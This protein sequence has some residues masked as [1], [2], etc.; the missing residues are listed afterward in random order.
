[1]HRLPPSLFRHSARARFL[2]TV[3]PRYAQTTFLMP[4]LSPTMEEGKIGTWRFKEG[5][6]FNEGDILLSVET[7]KAE[8]EV[9]AQEE[10][11]V[12]KVLV[13]DHAE[14]IKV[15]R[16]IAILVEKGEDISNLTLPEEAAP[17]SSKT[18][19][20]EPSKA[21]CPP[22]FLSAPTHPKP[23]SPAVARLLAINEIEDAG[24][25]IGLGSGKDGRL[26][27]E[28]VLRFV[29]TGEKP[30]LKKKKEEKVT[31]KTESGKPVEVLDGPAFR[32][33]IL[34]GMASPKPQPSSIPSKKAPSSFDYDS[35]LAGYRAPPS[36]KPVVVPD[37]IIFDLPSSSLET[38]HVV[39][40]PSKRDPFTDLLH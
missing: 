31:K 39:V 24:K 36:R 27:K 29:S 4:S 2:S 20:K 25:K 6:E 26:T 3:R 40:P 1:M 32:R 37:T 35:I 16:P 19:S 12:G 8:V 28:D 22:H 11:R 34:A 30:D 33:L 17:S 23:I 21:A 9:E 14:G 13:G 7:D 38:A 10:G 15:G 18:E 5:D